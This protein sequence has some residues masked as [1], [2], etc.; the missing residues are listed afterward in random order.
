MS[1]VDRII[2]TAQRCIASKKH[3]VTDAMATKLIAEIARLRADRAAVIR[4][5]SAV[6]RTHF[7]IAAS[8][9]KKVGQTDYNRGAKNCASVIEAGILEMIEQAGGE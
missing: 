4:E 2:A 6:A 9:Q 1:D 8:A 5:C 3:R 7:D